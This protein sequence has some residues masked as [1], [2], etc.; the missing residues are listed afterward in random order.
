MASRFEKPRAARG[1]D[2]AVVYR[3]E[4]EFCSWPFLGGLWRTRD[5]S[6]LLSFT[7]NDCN[8]GSPDAVHHDVLSVSRGRLSTVRS[9]DDGR[10]WDQDSV[11]SVFDLKTPVEEITAAD[12]SNEPPVDFLDP[13]VLIV[14]GALPALFVAGAKPWLRLSVDGGRTWRPPILLPMSGLSSVSAQG[15]AMVRSDGV[16]LLGMTAVTPDGWTR[17]PLIYGSANGGR[18]WSFLSFMTPEQ[19][20][21]SAVSEKKGSPRFGAHRYF[22]AR[23]IRLSDDRL[24][25][26]MRSQRDPTSILWTEVF[27]SEDG[28]RTWR[29]L[30]RVNDWGAPGDLVQLKDGRIV[31]VYGYRLAPYGVRARVSEDG[32]RTWGSE[33]VLRDD[34]GSW[35]LGYPRVMEVDAGTV[36]AAYYMNLA[37][38]PIQVNGGV[39]H[40]ARTLF[41]PD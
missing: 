17:R 40:I 35:D 21:G 30:S 8:Y 36:L 28:G 32:G 26:S 25:A 14:S 34:G 9:H 31:C 38:D 6:I 33:I 24:I 19:D 15:S 7:R 11:Q 1:A 2:H 4:A 10:S 39:R 16:S 37:S 20:D 18:S 22:Y 27:E 12:Y 13:D 3:N 23:P 29:F 41:R 5:G